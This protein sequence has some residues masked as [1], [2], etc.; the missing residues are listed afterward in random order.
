M[1]LELQ[2]DIIY[3]P[4]QSRRL[5]SSL[6]LN[7][8][9]SGEKFCT[10]NCLYCQYGWHQCVETAKLNEDIFPTVSEILDALEGTLKEL[11]QPLRY[12]TFSGN[13]EASL[14][15]DFDDIVTGLII[16][17]N[18]Y[19]PRVKTAILSNSSLVGNPDI[20]KTIDR[21]DEPIMKLDAGCP[22][23]FETYNRPAKDIALEQI[24]SGLSALK[25]VTIQ[26]LFSKGSSGNDTQKNLAAWVS[27]LKRI[28][29]QF[30]QIY[31]LD[32]SSPSGAISKLE[33]TELQRIRSLVQDENIP[34][35][36]F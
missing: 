18:R 9:P 8:L 2:K 30:V 14:H 35:K 16:L 12:I 17:R 32:R 25:K 36:V 15:P 21:L 20:R 22:E 4:V 3:G 33:K 10:F 11:T 1:L 13:G 5:G 28:S 34:A 31:T 29:P 19:A 23:T 7:I 27:Q 24:V 26:A 6:G